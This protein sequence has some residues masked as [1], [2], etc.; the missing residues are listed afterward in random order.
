MTYDNFL[1]FLDK[2]EDISSFPKK[3]E[4]CNNNLGRPIGS[5]SGRIVYNIDGSKVFKV[6]KNTKG[7]AQNETEI[8]AS[9]RSYNETIV[10]KVFNHAQNNMWIVAELGKKVSEKR[11]KQLTHIPSLFVLGLYL[12]NWND[13]NNGKRTIFHIDDGVVEEM[14]ENEWVRELTD[15]VDSNNHATGDM[16]KTSTYGEVI[17]NG[18]PEIVLTDYGLSQDVFDTYYDKFRKKNRIYEL[19]NFADGNDDILSDIGN[20][21]MEAQHGMWALMPYSVSDGD[22]VVNME[23]NKINFIESRNKYPDKPIKN[24]GYL[25]DMF[26]ECVNNIHGLMKKTKNKKLFYNNLLTLQEYLI[27]QNAYDRDPL[28]KLIDEKTDLGKFDVKRMYNRMDYIA[29]LLFNIKISDV[30]N[31][32]YTDREIYDDIIRNKIEN[33]LS[34]NPEDAT[35]YHAMLDHNNINEDSTALY[36]TD[37][38]IG[39]TGFPAYAQGYYG[40]DTDTE[41]VDKHYVNERQLHWIPGS[42]AV[43]IK[44]K[45][46]IGGNG[47]GTST[48]CNTG[49]IDNIKLSVLEEHVIN[50]TNLVKLPAY[51]MGHTIDVAKKIFPHVKQLPTTLKGSTEV[52]NRYFLN[53]SANGGS[54][55]ENGMKHHLIYT[56]IQKLV[57]VAKKMGG[58]GFKFAKETH[59]VYFTIRDT[60]IRISDHYKPFNGLNIIVQWNTDLISAIP[61]FQ[62]AVG[63]TLN[64]FAEST[65]DFVFGDGSNNTGVI[66]EKNIGIQENISTFAFSNE[67][68]NQLNESSNMDAFVNAL[69]QR[70]FMQAIEKI[71]G[72]L[73]FVNNFGA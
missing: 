39:N 66:N 13:M 42:Q 73:F 10:A 55:S 52:V 4:F 26:H 58:G 44:K 67:S 45:C 64:V 8:D 40:D 29:N 19:Y 25:T 49:D 71:G 54:F 6:A 59:S 14:E 65:A 68:S 72:R 30:I 23:E 57:D 35:F 62:S 28:P 48:A 53:G 56:V 5:G 70:P 33:Y 15:F 60:D 41:D 46:R 12:R 17:R 1:S 31:F 38:D 2:F 37:G 43:T 22:G 34:K 27:S 18:Q 20:V 7:V 3:I 24:M 69:K 36:S 21:G 50:A 16:N 61:A 9:S 11:I 32:Y 51:S 63:K 47:D